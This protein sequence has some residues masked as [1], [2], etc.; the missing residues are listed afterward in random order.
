MYSYDLFRNITQIRDFMSTTLETSFP[1]E[2]LIQIRN[3]GGV[4]LLSVVIHLLLSV[5][6]NFFVFFHV[7]QI[8]EKD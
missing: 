2:V 1:L 5:Y 4:H 6:L 7:V 3:R 8:I